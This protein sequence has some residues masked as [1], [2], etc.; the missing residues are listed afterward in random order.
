MSQS[1]HQP[2]ASDEP[3]PAVS[4]S[5]T[6]TEEQRRPSVTIPCPSCDK[7]VD[8]TLGL[9]DDE[10]EPSPSNH[11]ADYPETEGVDGGAVATDGGSTAED[12]QPTAD[13]S[14]ADPM[15]NGELCGKPVRCGDCG[16]EFELLFYH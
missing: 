1:E 15:L 7:R 16:D 4:G 14:S 10:S 2:S 6:A 8:A 13:Q 11:G 3:Q 5:D 12:G 9:S